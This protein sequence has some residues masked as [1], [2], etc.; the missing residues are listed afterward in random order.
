M[1]ENRCILIKGKVW[2]YSKRTQYIWNLILISFFSILSSINW[3]IIIEIWEIRNILSF[4]FLLKLFYCVS[5][6]L[7]LFF[8]FSQIVSFKNSGYPLSNKKWYFFYFVKMKS[9]A[10]FSVKNFD[11]W[12]YFVNARQFSRIRSWITDYLVKAI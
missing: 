2:D 6:F 8:Y 11:N 3:E 9:S 1:W 5:I 4:T 7:K 12:Y 10:H